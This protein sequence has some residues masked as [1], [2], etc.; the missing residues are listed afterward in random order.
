[1]RAVR[2]RLILALLT[3]ALAGVSCG[4]SPGICAG[5]GC[6]PPPMCGVGCQATCGCCPC[7]AGE[8][9]GDLVCTDYGCYAPAPPMDGGIDSGWQPAAACALPFD[10]GPCRADI[11][12]YAFVSGA[13][14]ARSYGGCDG[15]D[16]RF[17]TLEEC[18][19]ACEG[20]PIPNG[21]PAGRVAQE[22]CLACG[23]AGGCAQTG[24]VCA[25]RCDVDAGAAAAGCA[26]DSFVCLGGVCHVGLCI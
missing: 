12:V 13:C 11:P 7:R 6:G 14:V 26:D 15:N 2:V 23:P 24:T 17:D 22:I 18:L 3:L 9:A 16:N 5:T 10:V 19:A 25:L 21:C 1:M 20:R 8:R 4:G